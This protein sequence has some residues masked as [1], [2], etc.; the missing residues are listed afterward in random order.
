M[1]SQDFVTGLSTLAR[2][3]FNEKVQWAFGLYDVNGDGI[4]E[5]NLVDIY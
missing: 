5:L 4:G 3:S 2:G 1:D